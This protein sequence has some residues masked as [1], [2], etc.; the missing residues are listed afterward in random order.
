MIVWVCE[1]GCASSCVGTW[2]RVTVVNRHVQSVVL[3]L[4][5]FAS[6]GAWV[7]ALKY[8]WL[9]ELTSVRVRAWERIACVGDW[10]SSQSGTKRV[11][12]KITK[13]CSTKGKNDQNLLTGVAGEFNLSM[14]GIGPCDSSWQWWV[15]TPTTAASS[16]SLRYRNQQ[17][18]KDH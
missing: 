1:C 11:N 13:Y 18:L 2:V 10:V 4:S 17:H 5:A 16:P 9:R 7:S 3:I 12:F 6:V 15:A 14:P 8:T